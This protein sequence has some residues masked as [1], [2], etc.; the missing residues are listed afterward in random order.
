MT[1]EQHNRPSLTGPE[2]AGPLQAVLGRTPADP[3]ITQQR[4]CRDR[5][6]LCTSASAEESAA[7][8]FRTEER[9]GECG[10]EAAAFP[11]CSKERPGVNAEGPS[12]SSYRSQERPG[13]RMPR[14]QSRRDRSWRHERPVAT[15][16]TTAPSF[17]LPFGLPE[18]ALTR[19]IADAAIP[20]LHPDDYLI[21]IQDDAMSGAGLARG[22]YAIVRRGIAPANGDV[23]VVMID[24][25]GPII[26]RIHHDSG[27]LWLMAAGAGYAEQHHP[28]DTFSIE[29]VVTARLVVTQFIR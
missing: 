27:G 12:I 19:R 9:F 16:S 10:G 24:H 6:N 18:D 21:T 25:V 14:E 26:R 15:D 20:G 1:M 3:A 4:G 23:C 11:N 29:G 13:V 7:L 2:Y 22:M 28:F 8:P 17:G 5:K